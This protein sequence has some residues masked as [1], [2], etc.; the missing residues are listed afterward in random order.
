MCLLVM[1]AAAFSQEG[2]KAQNP[3]AKLKQASSN[4]PVQ[5][6]TEKTGGRLSPGFFWSPKLGKFVFF[7]GLPGGKQH[8]DVEYFDPASCTWTNA[9]PEGAPYKAE[10]GPTDA[11]GHSDTRDGWFPLTD[12][13]GVSRIPMAG[14]Y[15]ARSAV[16][17]HHQHSLDPETNTLYALIHN[18][19][20]VLDIKS[21]LWS[22]P[23]T[24]E[25]KV[26][27]NLKNQTAWGI[28]GFEGAGC[29][30]KHEVIH[31]GAL[32]WDPVNKEVLSVGGSAVEKGGT[33]GSWVYRTGSKK[34]EK[35][36]FG[37]P[38]LKEVQKKAG[39][40]RNR[41]WAL[42]SHARSRFFITESPEEAKADLSALCAQLKT[43]LETFVKDLG[44]ARLQKHF[45]AGRAYSK[46][47][48]SAYIALLDTIKAKLSTT[49]DAAFLLEFRNAHRLLEST[50]FG[51]DDQPSGRAHSQAVFD[52]VNKKIVLFGGEGMD[53]SLGDTWAY[54]CRTRT[55]EQKF[56]KVSPAP[57]GA[58]VLAWLP[59]AKKVAMVGGYS[60]TGYR[61]FEIWTYD[62]AK[63]KWSL[64]KSVSPGKGRYRASWRGL[65]VPA[66]Y[67]NLATVGAVN[68]DDVMVLVHN[69]RSNRYTWAV[70]IDT[71]MQADT[72]AS[73]TEAGSMVFSKEGPDYYSFYDRDSSK[74]KGPAFYE[75]K[76]KIIPGEMKAF[77]K[78]LP[79]NVWVAFPKPPMNVPHRDY[80]TT[81]YDP[82]RKQFLLWGG[83]HVNYFGT[84]VSHFSLRT[85]SWTA[86]E[87][88]DEPLEPC[89][90]MCLK[91]GMSFRHR[92]H[93]TSHAYQ[94][95]DYDYTTGLML[96]AKYGKTY[97]YDVAE[98]RWLWP[99]IEGSAGGI[100]ATPKGAIG[101]RGGSLVRFDRKQ[102]K[103]VGF[104]CKSK[105]KPP[106]VSIDYSGFCYD[107]KR[108]AV[109]YFNRKGV[110][111]FDL[112]KQECKRVTVKIENKHISGYLREMLYI[113]EIDRIM[114]HN[115]NKP[116]HDRHAFW[117]PEKLVW[118]EADIPLVG[119]DG[120]T[121]PAKG[122]GFSTGNGLMRDH[123][124]GMI[125][126]G[127][128]GRTNYA[129]KL[130]PEKLTFSEVK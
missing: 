95:Y 8:Y 101:A 48:I 89:F 87:V 116:N 70:K 69:S 107:E 19:M 74:H 120:K 42:L 114:F 80:G 40:L 2:D 34:W 6:L 100:R 97:V 124:N 60:K 93:I 94:Y 45:E 86:G 84:E 64:H 17:M 31:W 10:T 33:P 85:G 52:P 56:P 66:S 16:L 73:G 79:V 18:R 9:Y 12:A 22:F 49:L 111:M 88:P 7:L 37:T 54:D 43:D 28:R 122:I 77:L 99:V 65:N 3:L 68:D 44:K 59:K 82:H 91:V 118:E 98:R 105:L 24:N 21:G 109:W 53:R 1:S 55:W 78:G 110:Y 76:A 123:L 23:D 108:D 121:K 113:P 102:W 62:T 130:D 57:V 71:T 41:S 126:V 15:Y 30:V 67:R 36:S 27:Q 51:L 20:A 5:L 25:K 128:A 129:L 125:F 127:G 115:R 29:F 13:K 61:P 75:K 63:N 106:G 39:E 38:K 117:N 90:G 58:H 96:V 11:P 83:G 119:S 92:P 14:G 103:W 81:R 47:K 104:P 50:V 4:Q 112:K 35:L 32:C 46:G 72:E 26:K